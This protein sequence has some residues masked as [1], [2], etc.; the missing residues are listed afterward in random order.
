MVD[1]D[2]VMYCIVDIGMRMFQPYEPYRAQDIIDRDY[3]CVEYTKDK[4][5]PR[6]GNAV[7]PPFAEELVRT[8][9]PELCQKQKMPTKN[10]IEFKQIQIQIVV[11]SF[12]DI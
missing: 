3:R 12:P 6:C 2:R 11:V 8:N 10:I 9:L 4:Q 5:V 1:I 7:P